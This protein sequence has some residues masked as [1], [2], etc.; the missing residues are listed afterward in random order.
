MTLDLPLIFNPLEILFDSNGVS[1]MLVTVECWPEEVVVRLKAPVSEATRGLQKEHQIALEQWAERLQGDPN[2]KAPMQL[3]PAESVLALSIT[4]EDD[5]GTHYL[6]RGS[7]VG[8]SGRM[9]TGEWY[10]SPGP[11]REATKLVCEVGSSAGQ[12][13]STTLSL[14]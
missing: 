11:P 1:I 2:A 4:L 10:L 7:A 3:R 13:K 9:F 6:L 14:R 5:V 12:R 8:G